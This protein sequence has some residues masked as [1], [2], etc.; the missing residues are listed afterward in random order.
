MIC[1]R[2]D[3]REFKAT[4]PVPEA[5]VTVRPTGIGGLE[6]EDWSAGSISLKMEGETVMEIRL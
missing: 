1:C 5:A 3:G 6:R 2:S 4:W